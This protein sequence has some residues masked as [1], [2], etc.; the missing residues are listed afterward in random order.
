MNGQNLPAAVDNLSSVLYPDLGIL[1]R[2]SI[3]GFL[4]LVLLHAAFG[5]LREKAWDRTGI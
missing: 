1:M 4:K 2:I 3:A 5:R